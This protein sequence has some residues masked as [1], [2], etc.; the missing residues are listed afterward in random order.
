M[1]TER[2]EQF[3]ELHAQLVNEVTEPIDEGE[4]LRYL[5]YP[6]GRRPNAHI[7]RLIGQWMEEAAQQSAPQ[8][9]YVVLPVLE[10]A[11]NRLKVR[12]ASGETEF[13]GAIGRFLGASRLIMAFIA[14]AGPKLER[15]ASRLMADGEE[16][17]AMVVNSVGA[18]RAEAAESAVIDRIRDQ[19]HAV[20]FSPTLPYSPGYCG[21]ALTEQT[22]LFGLFDGATAGVT[23]S[24][25]CL[26]HPIKS[27]S[28]LVGLAPAEEVVNEGSPCD[29]CELHTCNMRR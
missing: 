14:T 25:D 12:S 13:R 21:M 27:V 7:E 19:L 28:G 20:G 5:G 4:V 11:G 3:I 18:E 6:V 22:R 23:L 26:M 15:L 29:R 2:L 8:A 16:L 10:K 17:P 1:K 9:A 24:P